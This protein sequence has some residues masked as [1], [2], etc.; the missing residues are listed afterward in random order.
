MH[1]K[2]R[3]L[4][5]P[6]LAAFLTPV[7]AATVQGIGSRDCTAYSR[8]TEIGSKEAID[9]Y[10]AWTQGY[11]SAWNSLNSRGSDIAVDSGAL[12]YWLGNYC[13]GQPSSSFYQAVQAFI[14]EQ[15][16]GQ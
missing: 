6:A 11:I 16:G 5:A 7:A 4:I 10:V 14:Q 3:W 9:A 1:A 12:V 13:G 2:L 15:G 8:S